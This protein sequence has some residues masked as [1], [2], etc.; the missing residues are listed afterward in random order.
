M[1]TV[2]LFENVLLNNHNFDILDM[3]VVDKREVWLKSTNTEKECLIRGL[4]QIYKEGVNVMEAAID[5]H[6]QLTEIISIFQPNFLIFSKVFKI[7]L[8]Y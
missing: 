5:A 1:P 4:E 3:E 2:A 8:D 7:T 6:S